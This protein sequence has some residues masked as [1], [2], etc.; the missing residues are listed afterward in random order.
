MILL[1]LSFGGR[2]KQ[3]EQL[4][5]VK[6]TSKVS[7]MPLQNNRTPNTPPAVNAKVYEVSE[8]LPL[9]PQPKKDTTPVVEVK[10]EPYFCSKANLTIPNQQH[11]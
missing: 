4:I 7:G 5:Y 1:Q 9:P 10:E 3:I 6:D 2:E 8:L 11:C